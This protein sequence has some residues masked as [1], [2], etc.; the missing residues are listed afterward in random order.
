MIPAG[1]TFPWTPGRTP[2][3]TPAHQHLGDLPC[4][5]CLP[6]P[7]S[8]LA[9]FIWVVDGAGF[10]CS[11]SDFHNSDKGINARCALCLV[12]GGL[13]QCGE[14]GSISPAVTLAVTTS[15]GSIPQG[16]W[17]VTLGACD[18]PDAKARGIF[19][20]P[21][22]PRKG[23]KRKRPDLSGHLLIGGQGRWPLA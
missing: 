22:K 5:L 10:Q 13:C 9:L 2:F 14:S 6:Q 16:T 3:P 17:A 15:G 1:L 20:H 21:R 19:Q 18:N 12:S 4:N 7:R 11:P 23:P 8:L